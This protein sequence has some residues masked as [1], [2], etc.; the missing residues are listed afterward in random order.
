[1]CGIAGIYNLDGEPGPTGLLKQM[2]DA[3]PLS[4]MRNMSKIAVLAQAQKGSAL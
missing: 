1:M 4:P 3:L 2:T